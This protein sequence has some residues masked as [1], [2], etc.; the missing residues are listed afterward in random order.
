MSCRWCDEIAERFAVDVN[1]TKAVPSYAL[2]RS[3]LRAAHN[4]F[5]RLAD[6]RDA[7]EADAA[8]WQD[9]ALDAEA[10]IAAI[11]AALDR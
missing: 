9:R 2:V 5:E 11:E 1:G 3:R 7:A 4:E 10:R 8:Y 6:E